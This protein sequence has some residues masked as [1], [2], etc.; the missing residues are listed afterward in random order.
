MAVETQTQDKIALA[1]LELFMAQGIKKTSV[2]EIA[3]YAGVT[4]VTVYRYYA[5]KRDVVRAAFLQSEQV[6]EQTRID[7][8]QNPG[9]DPEV[10][11]DQIGYGLAAQP[12]GDL[13]ARLD[14]L[15]RVYPDIYAEFQQVRV[16]ALSGVFDRLFALAEQA[17]RL[18]P[19]VNREVAQALFWEML[20]SVFEN[21]R[22]GALGLSGFE[23]YRAVRDIIFYGIAKH[24][25]D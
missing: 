20:V 24:P 10:Y 5:D 23:L 19:E 17:G 15:R 8:E 14:E 1:A 4:R 2:D 3:Q 9:C 13:F 11:L 21:P 16:A 7:L 18:R 22:L 12:H 6:F 25:G